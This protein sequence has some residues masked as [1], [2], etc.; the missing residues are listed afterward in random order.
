MRSICWGGWFSGGIRERSSR[1]ASKT[2]RSSMS[3]RFNHEVAQ[4]ASENFL[5]LSSEVRSFDDYPSSA[6][7]PD[8]SRVT[9]DVVGDVIVEFARDGSVL[10]EIPLLDLVDPYRVGYDSLGRGYWRAT[11]AAL[12]D[13]EPDVVDWAH[14]NALVYD[15]ETDSFVVALR[16]QDAIVKIGR[17]TREIA[18]ILGPPNGWSGPVGAPAP[19]PTWRTGMGRITVMGSSSRR[20]GRCCCTTTGTLG[21]AR[22]RNRCRLRIGTVRAVEYDVDEATREVGEVWTYGGPDGER[23]YSS[24]LSDAD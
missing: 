13:E 11:Y 9:Q 5:T 24:F 17:S 16:H 10:T 3:T 1:Q 4:L 7:D 6:D 15:A 18:W 8:A 20:S 14:A 2:A 19:T 21:R 23:F 22:S 12:M